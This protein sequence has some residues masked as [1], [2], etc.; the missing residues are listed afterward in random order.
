[1]HALGFDLHD[2]IFLRRQAHLAILQILLAQMTQRAEVLLGLVDYARESANQHVGQLRPVFFVVID[3]YCDAW[4]FRDIAHPPEGQ[5][6]LALGFLVDREVDA[7]AVEPVAERHVVRSAAA[8]GGC[9]MSD[10][11]AGDKL[12]HVR[13]RESSSRIVSR[14]ANRFCC[15]HRLSHRSVFGRTFSRRSKA[16]RAARASDSSPMSAA[17]NASAAI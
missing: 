7:L 15:C 4:I 13:F 11:R 10:A 8:V 5:T 6:F 1:M 3:H 2:W 14:G 17:A 16:P 9:Q 12:A